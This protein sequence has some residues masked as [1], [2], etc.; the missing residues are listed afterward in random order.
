MGL[1]AVAEV[2]VREAAVDELKR[3]TDRVRAHVAQQ[4]LLSPREQEFNLSQKLALLSEMRVI[5]IEVREAAIL[6]GSPEEV[7]GVGHPV[8]ESVHGPLLRLAVH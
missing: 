5:D 7:N 6:N 1:D 3:L 2:V 8:R 4:V